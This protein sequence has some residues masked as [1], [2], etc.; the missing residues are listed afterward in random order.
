MFIPAFH[1]NVSPEEKLTEEW[2]MKAVQ[3]SVFNSN[4]L[5]LLHGK[6]I[7][8]I[9]EY[10]SG[11]FDM[12]PFKLKFKSMRKALKNA[13]KNI[14]GTLS[15]F[16]NTIDTVGVSY[17]PLPLIPTKLNSAVSTVQKIPIEVE[18]RAQDALAMKKRTE[19]ITFLKNKPLIE[20]D[21]Q[22]LADQ[23]DI[24]KVDFG[25]TKN[26]A[27]KY[28]AT[29]MGLDLNQPDEEDMFV[30]VHYSLMVEKALE[31]GLQQV[32]NLKKGDQCRLLET[33]DHFKFGVASNRAYTS[34]MTGLPELDYLYP[35]SVE[36]PISRLPDLSDNS[37][38]IV[39]MTPT[40]LELFNYFS[41]EI[42]DMAHLEQMIN[43]S[44]EDGGYCACNAI[45]KQNEK[46]WHTY[47]VNLK[48]IEIKSVDWVGVNTK[49][50]SKRGVTTL[51]NDSEKCTNKIWGQN[52]YGFYWLVNTQRC[53]GIHRLGFSHRTKGQEAFQNFSTN[54]YRSQPK[55]AVELSI[56]ENK[57]A[58]MAD[59]KLEHLI[60]KSL[61]P[62]KYVDLKYI[63]GALSGLKDEEN[64]YTMQDLIN[65]AWEQNVII[66]DTE[67]FDGKNDGQYKP[68]V[69]LVGGVKLAEAQG[70]LTIIAVANQNIS[71]YTGINEQLTGQSANPEGLVGLQKL[72][73]N[74]S[75]NAI[76]YVNIATKVQYE[77]VFNNWANL[78]QGAIERGGKTRQAIVNFIGMEDT[79]LLD[80]LN[81]VPLHNLTIKVEVGQREEER[82]LYFNK[83]QELK[84]KG[85]INAADEYLLSGIDNA[86]ERFAMLAIK[87][88]KFLKAQEEKEMRQYQNQQQ[89]VQQ[90]GEN[91][92]QAE[93]VKGQQQRQQIFDKGEVNAKLISLSNQ[94]GLTAQQTE[95]ILK[96]ALQRD[97]G[98]DQTEKGIKLIQAKQSANA[99]EPIPAL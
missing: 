82:Q 63:R 17:T 64:P 94:L 61:P 81:E 7:K 31:K 88:K 32:Y 62:G 76:Y 1:L 21:L 57:K 83:L 8:E 89:L 20:S 98:I 16:A 79:D 39:N 38:R 13:P 43:G 85:V 73:I 3:F 29:P 30:K 12:T 23:M 50:K 75:I 2:C 33:Y 68:F 10:A 80:G 46:F 45:E 27:V 14:D 93:T 48:Y 72:L 78:L 53:F 47:R 55:S 42:R 95:A 66:G 41:D 26:S 97:R 69:E 67:G 36:T 56:G 9:E 87:E 96:R 37:H 58:Q 92:V 25:S 65:L 51:T 70:Y 6:N 19:D 40:V 18:C 86:K 54:I 52:T 91:M 22:D 5:N 71:N 11:N 28:S 4:N 34:S 15:D 60:L 59:I 90:Q 49:A 44:K 74:S 24:G 99:Q 35:S 84:Q 77:S